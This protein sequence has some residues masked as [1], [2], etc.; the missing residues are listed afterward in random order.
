M[1]RRKKPTDE[2]PEQQR[3]RMILETVSNY[4]DRSDKTSWQRKMN[5]LEKLLAEL[6]PIEDMLL[7]LNSRKQEIIDKIVILRKEMVDNC[8]HPYDLLVLKDTHVECKFCDRKISYNH[9]QFNNI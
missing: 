6:K 4:P 2:T 7:D 1:A 5:N 8:F 3:E 9:D